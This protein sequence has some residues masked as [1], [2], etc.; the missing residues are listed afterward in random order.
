MFTGYSANKCW[1]GELIFEGCIIEI[2]S[3]K[4]IERH[5]FLLGFTIC[6]YQFKFVDQ[7]FDIEN[8]RATF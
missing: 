3:N 2:K 1:R 8:L 7:N 5:I 6:N 4:K